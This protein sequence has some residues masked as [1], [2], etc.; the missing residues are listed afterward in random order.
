MARLMER[1]NSSAGCNVQT[2]REEIESLRS[3]L[4]KLTADLY[5]VQGKSA[6]EEG[7]FEQNVDPLLQRNEHLAQQ[8]AETQDKLYACTAENQ[9]LH[10]ARD[11]SLAENQSLRQERD[12]TTAE[13]R[14]VRQAYASREREATDSSTDLFRQDRKDSNRTKRKGALGGLLAGDHC[15]LER[16]DV[17]DTEMLSPGDSEMHD[18]V[19]EPSRSQHHDSS[20]GE[21]H[22]AEYL[23]ENVKNPLRQPP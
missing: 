1:N 13:L 2:I 10:K 12:E 19:T 22:G 18:S 3:R 17:S 6:V 4:R 16:D 15:R 5:A 7:N 14:R 21:A 20:G 23:H 8:L 11:A 9:S